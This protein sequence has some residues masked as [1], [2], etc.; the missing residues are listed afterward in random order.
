MILLITTLVLFFL[1]AISYLAFRKISCPLVF[2]NILFFVI[3]LGLL[4]SPFEINNNVE[5]ASLIVLLGFVFLNIGFYIGSTIQVK[6]T[7]H[8][9]TRKNRPFYFDYKLLYVLFVVLT[10][11]TLYYVKETRTLMNKGYSLDMIRMFYFS[12]SEMVEQVTG[13]RRNIYMSIGTTYIYEPCQYLS[14]ALM[15]L[16]VFN[17][18]FLIENKK[19]KILLIAITGLNLGIS[20]LTNGGRLVLYYLVI[21]MFLSF[22]ISRN[23][24]I[25]PKKKKKKRIFL[26]LLMVIIPLLFVAI[27]ITQVRSNNG[28]IL[29]SVF[30][31]FCGSIPNMEINLNNYS[32]DYYTYGLTFVSGLIRPF[33]TALRFLLK[34]PIPSV[35]DASDSF[36][37]DVGTTNNIGGGVEYNAF[38]PMFYYFY[39]D[40]GYVGLITESFI[41][42]TIIALIYKKVKTDKNNFKILTLYLVIMIGLS[43][44]FIRWQIMSVGYA[45]TFIYLLI[46]FRRKCFLITFSAKENVNSTSNN[47]KHCI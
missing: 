20:M 27:Y 45:L 43:M 39:R 4:I 3:F 16:A 46:F 23:N 30:Y 47:K 13:Y 8:I 36:L 10:V 31:Y 1:L 26:I 5:K 19:T 6:K 33:F 40:F 24:S 34:I 9:S 11:F 2:L 14:I 38:V 44:A 22:S 7:Q 18:E 37:F 32:Y 17:K 41:L 28:G 12:G 35:F 42:G 15:S 29:R 21:C 25:V